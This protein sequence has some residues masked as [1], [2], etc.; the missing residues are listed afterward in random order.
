VET[1][2]FSLLRVWDIPRHRVR[3]APD[4]LNTEPSG[5]AFN[6]FGAPKPMLARLIRKIIA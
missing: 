3:E 4:K 6:G 5:E 1:L 2:L